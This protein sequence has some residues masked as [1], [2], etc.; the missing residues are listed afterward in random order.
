VED[1]GIGISQDVQDRLFDAFTQA[2]SSTTRRYGGTGLGLAISKR[3]AELMGGKVGVSSTPG[4]GSTFWFTIQSELREGDASIDDVRFEGTRAL[5]VD[6]HEINR[7]ILVRQLTYWGMIV[8]TASDGQ[9]ALERFKA[10]SLQQRPYDVALVD[11]N[12]PHLDGLAM[13]RKVASTGHPP[14][15]MALLTSSAQ[16]G[17]ASVAVSAGYVDYLTKPIR[18]STLERCVRTLVGQARGARVSGPRPAVVE[19]P[20]KPVPTGDA[21]RVLLAEDNPVNQK[22]ALRMLERLGIAVDVVASGSEAVDA[23]ARKHYDM[24]L[25]DCQMPGMDGYEATAEI[26]RRED[27]RRI[28]IIALTANAMAGDRERC[29]DAGMDDYVAKPVTKEMLETAIRQWGGL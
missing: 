19:V 11:L 17:E 21:L 20:K 5:V 9:E 2:D 13:A 24:I 3:L 4:N 7:L 10:A 18:Q 27:G 6:D 8:E 12:M 15:A 1:T 29:I 25:M 22:V 16:R 14:V 23:V 26:R 28:P